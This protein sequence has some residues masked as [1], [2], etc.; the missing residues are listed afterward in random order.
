MAI[1]A[2]KENSEIFCAESLD[3][4]DVDLSG[5]FQQN[6]G[7]DESDAMPIVT[8]EKHLTFRRW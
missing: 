5:H 4:D 6:D 3:E 7:K 2:Q 1:I 8:I